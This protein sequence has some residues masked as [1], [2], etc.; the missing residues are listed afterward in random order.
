MS[1]ARG[2][3]HSMK[4]PVS[5]KGVSP[6]DSIGREI[7]GMRVRVNMKPYESPT[8]SEISLVITP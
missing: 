7:R 8:S 3:R 5:L 1:D 4:L 2:G 6:I